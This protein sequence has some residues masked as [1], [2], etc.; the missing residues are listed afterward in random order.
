VLIAVCAAFAN[1]WILLRN[2]L[3]N[4]VAWYLY[5][6]RE[7]LA[8]K[9]LYIDFVETNP[10][11][12]CFLTAIP[13]WMGQVL[14]VE[15]RV[16]WTV[17]VTCICVGSAA[18]AARFW[19]MARGAQRGAETALFLF[20]LVIT[21]AFFFAYD[22]G[23][24][25][26]LGFVASLPLCGLIGARMSGAKVG[27]AVPVVTAI[28]G[29]LLLALKPF[30]FIPWLLCVAWALA[31][32]GWR[33]AARWPETYI[34]PAM[35]LAQPALILFVTP[36]YIGVARLVASLYSA[37]NSETWGRL[38]TER[39]LAVTLVGGLLTLLYRASTEG[40]TAVRLASLFTM[41]WYLS[42]LLQRKGWHYHDLPGVAALSFAAWMIVIDLAGRRTE[43]A[44][45]WQTALRAATV[46]FLLMAGI[47]TIRLHWG[48]PGGNGNIVPIVEREA[49]G[50]SIIALA[51]GMSAFPLVNDSGTR[52]AVRYNSLWPIP[53]LYARQVQA[54]TPDG[55]WHYRRPEQMG[56]VEK[57]MFTDVASDLA[58]EPPLLIFWS[59]DQQGMGSLK[60][61]LMGYFA[62]DD[63]VRTA[64]QHYDRVPLKSDYMV[65]RHITEKAASR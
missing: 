33:R 5:L 4:D 48:Y 27:A 32:C 41:G 44:L 21:L 13:V 55:K 22:F 28:I 60:V 20:L 19:G 47:R 7:L 31:V 2:P 65:F 10:P 30:F 15:S 14:H 59:R 3:N 18:A 40:R 54:G 16:V 37:Y 63:R 29:G 50:K 51:T 24:R 64:F 62:Q 53:G 45:R 39:F 25:D 49:R 17:L 57:Q 23:Q 8:G 36:A 35:S 9:H 61:D 26:H 43:R 12:I 42:G 56:A 38:L 1:C 52:L 34:V 11:L 46:L 58:T 6:G